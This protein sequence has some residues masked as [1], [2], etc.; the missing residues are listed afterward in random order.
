M[1]TE[2][3]RDAERLEIS[4][5]TAGFEIGT[6][7][8]KLQQRLRELTECDR[9]FVTDLYWFKPVQKCKFDVRVER[10]FHDKR[11]PFVT[12]FTLG[13]TTAIGIANTLNFANGWL[14]SLAI[15]PRA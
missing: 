10:E 3:L 9:V 11:K 5:E 8:E 13:D 12:S 15:N 1:N 14:R 4:V 2:K 6:T 7:A